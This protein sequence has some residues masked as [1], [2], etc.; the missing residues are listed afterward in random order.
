MGFYVDPVIRTDPF[1]LDVEP[2]ARE[3]LRLVSEGRPLVIDYYAR[4]YRG[5]TVGDVIVGFPSRSLEPCYPELAS[6]DDV[7][8][9]AHHRL[10]GV[11][12]AGATLRVTG[13]WILRHF[14]IGLAR[15]DLL[16]EFIDHAGRR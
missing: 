11:L 4:R 5:S 2:V 7:R 6:I 9:L 14:A 3:Y 1:R 12:E 16:F 10:I 8:V 13:P 15:P